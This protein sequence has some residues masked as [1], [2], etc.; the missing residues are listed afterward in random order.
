MNVVKGASGDVCGLLSAFGDAFLS[1]AT[2]GAV[3]P[4]VHMMTGFGH[5]CTRT[6][7]ADGRAC[8]EFSYVIRLD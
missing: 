4:V 2:S 1:I 6:K 5:D 8:L 3:R 7:A